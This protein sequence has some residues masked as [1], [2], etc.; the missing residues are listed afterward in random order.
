MDS[1]RPY[2]ASSLRVSKERETLR[3]KTVERLREAILNQFFSPGDRLIERKL[4]ELTGVSRTSV[5]EALRQL[6]SEG[7]IETIPNR[8]P[9]VASLSL[10]DAKHI[11]EVREAMEGLA[12][13]LFIE[14]ASKDEIEALVRTGESVVRAVG[15]RDV[16]AM[17][18]ALDDF[19]DTLFD[20]CANSVASELMRTLRARMHYLRATTMHGQTDAR[21]KESMKNFRR[22]IAAAKKRDAAKT[23]EACVTQARHAATVARE[24]LSAAEAG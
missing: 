16:P 1:K 7:L 4:C 23:A 17:L 21:K 6:E 20:G 10:E 11:Y 15:E 8:G 13:R 18:N 24:V 5:R 12:A 3:E 2:D 9:I 14:R 22:I 19:Y